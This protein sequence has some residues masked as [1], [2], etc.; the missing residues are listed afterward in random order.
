[1]DMSKEQLQELEAFAELLFSLS[2]L[3][4]LMD[5]DQGSFVQAVEE[6]NEV[7]RAI[8]RG[9]LRTEAKIRKG[10][11]ELAQGGSGSAQ[12]Q[13]AEYAKSMR[14]QDAS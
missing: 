9:R 4:V 1:M 14:V 12:Q 5:K 2:E 8:E 6:G 10:V 7:G 11:L 3:E 13:A